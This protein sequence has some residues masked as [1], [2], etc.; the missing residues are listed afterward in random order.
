MSASSG[1]RSFAEAMRNWRQGNKLSFRD[2]GKL[3]GVTGAHI[4][5]IESGLKKP[6]PGLLSR[7]PDVLIDAWRDQE[8]EVIRALAEHVRQWRNEQGRDR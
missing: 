5:N 3:F 1:S 7:M 4:H 6:S 2:A 8:I